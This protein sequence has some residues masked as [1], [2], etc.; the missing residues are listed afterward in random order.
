MGHLTLAQ[1]DMLSCPVL[2]KMVVT[3][4][5]WKLKGKQR[6]RLRRK[7]HEKEQ[8]DPVYVGLH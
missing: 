1:A 3:S 2:A 5:N 7:A 8:V 6:E 4:E